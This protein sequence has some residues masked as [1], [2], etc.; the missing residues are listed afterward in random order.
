MIVLLDTNSQKAFL[1]TEEGCTHVSFAN[2]SA[3][4]GIIG[5]ELV[6]YVTAGVEA[7]AQEIVN[8]VNE[9]RGVPAD[10]TQEDSGN[11]YLRSTR[12]G[13]LNVKIDAATSLQLDGPLKFLAVSSLSKN[14]LNHDT[15]KNLLKKGYLQ[16]V[17]YDEKEHLKEEGI[18]KPFNHGKK[19]KVTQQSPGSGT[20]GGR[21]TIN[22]IRGED[23][24]DVIELPISSAG[25]FRG[26][27]NNESS[28]LPKDLLT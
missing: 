15:V 12:N 2:I 28:L 1:Y 7:N 14:I 23:H 22:D 9:I 11:M 5:D 17:S 25:N 6:T 26:G 19:Q 20:G 27:G 3:I 18:R 13:V 10:V 24:D 8:V 4:E 16:L 21:K